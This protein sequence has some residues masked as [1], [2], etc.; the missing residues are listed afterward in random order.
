MLESIIHAFFRIWDWNM[1]VSLSDETC[2]MQ[3]MHM[4]TQLSNPSDSAF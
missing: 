4:N 3:K 1:P 2:W